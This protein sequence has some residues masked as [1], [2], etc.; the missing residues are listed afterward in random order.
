[1]SSSPPPSPPALNGVNDS[2]HHAYDARR[3][4]N[5]RQGPPVLL[6]LADTITLLV[7]G[8]RHEHSL[9]PEL[10]H[11]IKAVV[12][13]PVAAYAARPGLIDALRARVQAARAE[14]DRLP[15]PE[16][17][18]ARLTAILHATQRFLDDAAPCRDTFAREVGPLLLEST[19]D[20]T[21]LQLDAL[22]RAVHVLFEQLDADAR[23]H[24]E[25]VVAGAH[26]ARTRSLGM[27]YFQK[28]LGARADAQLTYAESVDDE[29]QALRLVRTRRLDRE[30]ATAFFGEPSRLERDVLGD[31]VRELL[32]DLTPRAAALMP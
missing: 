32:R 13:A 2:F 29:E 21:H 22:D 28:L 9:S 30:I 5:P 6:V 7:D 3:D 16:S 26:Q 31:A 24:V 15:M 4:E 8:S 14:V 23:A 17:V 20:A 11:V 1:M 19:A 18:R 10:F 12:H 25:V 27:Q